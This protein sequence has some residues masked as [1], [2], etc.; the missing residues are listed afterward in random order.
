MSSFSDN[1]SEANIWWFDGLKPRS[2]DSFEEFSALFLHHFTNNK[3]YY[4]TPLSLFS[5]KQQGWETLQEYIQCFY[6]IALEVLA[7]TLEIPMSA[8][9]YEL[10]K[11][12]FSRS[13]DKKSP[14]SYDDLMG[15]V[16]KYINMEEAQRT[17]KTEPN[18]ACLERVS[19]RE[20]L[21]RSLIMG[22][23]NR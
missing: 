21:G 22:Q 11:G 8:F 3:R 6:H 1:L 14:A 19:Q 2:I 9:S 23:A 12:D 17:R 7:A 15:R 4:N 5:L 13:L 10:A 16:E 18:S 20:G